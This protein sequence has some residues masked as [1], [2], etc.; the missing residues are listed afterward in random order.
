M[1]VRRVQG[2]PAYERQGQADAARLRGFIGQGRAWLRA[3][4]PCV[5]E[6]GCLLGAP[7]IETHGRGPLA[8][9]FYPPSQSAFSLLQR[10]HADGRGSASPSRSLTVAALPRATVRDV[11]SWIRSAHDLVLAPSETTILAVHPAWSWLANGR[12]APRNISM[13]SS[14][15]ARGLRSPGIAGG[16]YGNGA[17]TLGSGRRLS[18]PEE[19]LRSSGYR[20]R[21]EC[22][23]LRPRGGARAPRGGGG[24]GRGR[25][26]ERPLKTRTGSGYGDRGGVK[27]HLTMER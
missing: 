7:L 27:R 15:L 8:S 21:Q 14:S 26:R 6:H 5:E 18:S 13:A 4:R 10:Q 25:E 16:R 22:H 12:T 11:R 17:A 23:L 2:G 1:R 19:R 24:S 3:P 20:E 9:G